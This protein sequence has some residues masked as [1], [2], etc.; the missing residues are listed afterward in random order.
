MCEVG[1]FETAKGAVPQEGRLAL[2]PDPEEPV[3]SLPELAGGC[4]EAGHDKRERF[5]P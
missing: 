1:T 3:L 4:G 2:L 5:A